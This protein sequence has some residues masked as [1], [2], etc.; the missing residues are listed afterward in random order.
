MRP[1]SDTPSSCMAGV[2][3]PLARSACTQNK[4][5]GASRLTYTMMSPVASV[6]TH[7]EPDHNDKH[8]TCQAGGPSDEQASA[9]T[10]RRT[11]VKKVG[12]GQMT[13]RLGTSGT[14]YFSRSCS[15]NRAITGRWSDP[16]WRLFVDEDSTVKKDRTPGAD[17]YM[18]RSVYEGDCMFLLEK[19]TS[20]RSH[21]HTTTHKRRDII[22]KSKRAIAR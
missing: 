22:L 5:Q 18:I 20:S 9:Q 2:L 12:R 15:E 13:W 11:S 21:L 7:I 14:V 17:R 19:V 8:P 6:N 4:R 3:K 10:P 1:I 16:N